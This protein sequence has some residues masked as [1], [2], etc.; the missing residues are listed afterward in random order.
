MR[1]KDDRFISAFAFST[2]SENGRRFK[3]A[4]KGGYYESVESAID[5]STDNEVCGRLRIVPKGKNI[6]TEYAFMVEN[7]RTGSRG[8]VEGSLSIFQIRG[9]GYIPL[10]FKEKVVLNEAW[11]RKNL[12]AL[13][14]E[15]EKDE[16]WNSLLEIVTVRTIKELTKNVK[17]MFKEGR[18]VSKKIVKTQPQYLW[19]PFILKGAYN[20]LYGKA[21]SMKSFFSVFLGLCIENGIFLCSEPKR[22]LYIDLEW[23]IEEL[24]RKITIVKRSLEKMGYSPVKPFDYFSKKNVSFFNPFFF[25]LLKKWVIEKKIDL[26]IVDSLGWASEGDIL[27]SGETLRF[28]NVVN[29]LFSVREGLTILFLHHISKQDIKGEASGESEEALPFGSSYIYNAMRSIFQVKKVSEVVEVDTEKGKV[30]ISEFEDKDEGEVVGGGISGRKWRLVIEQKKN[31]AGE[32]AKTEFVWE[33]RET[34]EGETE[35]W[36]SYLGRGSIREEEILVERKILD[37]LEEKGKEVGIKELSRELGIDLSLVRRTVSRLRDAGKIIKVDNQKVKIKERIILDETV[38]DIEE[39]REEIDVKTVKTGYV[40]TEVKTEEVEEV[41]EVEEA[42]EA[43]E[44]KKRK[45]AKSMRY[46]DDTREKDSRGNVKDDV[47][48][49]VYVDGEALFDEEAVKVFN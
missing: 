12:V 36:I 17:R 44:R 39:E 38:E 34:E 24:E 23:D 32:L 29:S 45:E 33:F 18:E 14:Q 11:R 2:L 21:G 10:L 30:D 19:E 16:D 9:N 22:V 46:I 8:E 41:E 43:E 20:L 1:I 5:Y 7:I 27:R 37:Y 35:V 4:L 13:L 26:L 48:E 3:V 31:N 6:M 25:S 49:E 47:I 15:R 40:N 28:L 42:E